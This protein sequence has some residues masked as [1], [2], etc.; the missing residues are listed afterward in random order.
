MIFQWD[1]IPGA[2]PSAD[3]EQRLMRGIRDIASAHPD[4]LVAVFV[5]G[6]VIGQILETVTRASAFSFS[7]ADNG[8]ISHIVVQSESI[9]LRRFNDTAH[10]VDEDPMAGAQLP[11]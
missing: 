11:T 8:S 5:H 9:T 1:V 6:G 10:L 7:G 3:F 2:E 4:Q